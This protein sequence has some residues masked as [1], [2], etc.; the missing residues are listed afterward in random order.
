MLSQIYLNRWHQLVKAILEYV[1]RSLKKNGITRII[2]SVCYKW[3]IIRE[4]FGNE[5]ENIEIVYSIEE[6]PLGTGGIKKALR[7]IR[8]N[9]VY[10]INGDTFFD[11]DL[12]FLTLE[13]NSKLTICLK[14]MKEIYRYGCVESDTNNF[15][16]GF[17]NKIFRD[18]GNINGGVYLMSKK[19]FYK[20]K[21]G[22]NF[23]F[24]EFI[25]LYFKELR[26]SVKVFDNYFIDIGIPEDYQ[27]A[28][29]S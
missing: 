4:H 10:V 11:I 29:R 12:K 23:S 7:Q 26:A 13:D 22:K 21:T 19:I 18:K 3:K 25:R 8:F 2:L 9:Q 16:T 24:E 15:V 28:K 6:E 27:K 1:F 17:S 5:F 14:P 20:L